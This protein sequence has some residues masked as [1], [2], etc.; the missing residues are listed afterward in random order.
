VSESFP[1]DVDALVEVLDYLNLG[2]YVTDTERRILLWNRK[3]E[4][5]TGH[6]AEKV[7]GTHCHD[8]VLNHIDKDG[9]EL[10]TT[11]LC[12][13]SRAMTVG[14]ESREP[15]LVYARRPD[16]SRVPVSVSAAPLRDKV[17]NIIGGIETFRDESLNILDLELAA[18][19]QRH[20]LP[21]V[22]PASHKVDFDVRYYPH[23]LVGG[24]FYDVWAVAEDR[25]G[26]FVADVQGHG[27]SAALYTMVLKSL[28]VGNSASAD[29]PAEFLGAMNRGLGNLLIPGGFAS[30]CYGVVDATD[31]TFE[32][33]GAGHPRPLCLSAENGQVGRLASD[34]ML[35]G[36]M[37]E[38]AYRS[39]VV[40]LAAGD[41]VVCYTDG[42]TEVADSKGT[43][44]TEDGLAEILKEEAAGRG[45]DLLERIY[46]RVL[47]YCGDVALADDVLL[48]SV[49]WEG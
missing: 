32:Y 41:V 29:K 49:T 45:E 16:G 24:D 36:I 3:A 27:V 34:G 43:M 30:A 19:I 37:G 40:E 12:P 28:L 10:C 14:R 17:G 23:A 1:L 18:R 6:R 33:C 13:L 46:R 15:I 35:L 8:N 39:A 26:V 25:Y 2:V 22:M 4:E 31:G 47:S 11:P 21:A 7:V 42:A 9:H 5:I 38:T 20:T 44:L 48:L